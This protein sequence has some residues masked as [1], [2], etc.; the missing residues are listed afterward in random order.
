MQTRQTYNSFSGTKSYRHVRETAPTGLKTGVKNDIFWSEIG[1]GFERTQRY[2]PTKNSQEYPLGD[3]PV[4]STN[5]GSFSKLWCSE[6][7]KNAIS[8]PKLIPILIFFFLKLLYGVKEM[9]GVY[10]DSIFPGVLH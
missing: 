8:V 1:S 7:V 5:D 6:H 10:V 3:L 9:C 4:E 2:T